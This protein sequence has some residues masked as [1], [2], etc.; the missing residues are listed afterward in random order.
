MSGFPTVA[1]E[2][3]VVQEPTIRFTQAGGT[4]LSLRCR[5]N[6]QVK[7]GNGVW[8]PGPNPLFIDVTVF[9]HHAANLAE[10]V[11]NGDTVILNG[12]LEQQDWTDKESGEKRSKVCIVAEEIG[13]SARWGRV[14]IDTNTSGTNA[15]TV[16]ASAPDN[17]DPWA[18]PPF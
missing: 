3:N 9:G 1:G 7:D 16:H 13:L 5:A 2:F 6:K 10:T 4:V 8:G 14:S 18:E 11:K 17:D 12:R 15:T